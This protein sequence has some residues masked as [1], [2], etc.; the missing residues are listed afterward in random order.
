MEAV[1][2]VDDGEHPA[3]KEAK[4]LRPRIVDFHAIFKIY[5]GST[6]PRSDVRRVPTGLR[7]AATRLLLGRSDDFADRKRAIAESWYGR[8]QAAAA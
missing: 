2:C 6:P 4:V 3:Q 1:R 7:R 8:D 5:C